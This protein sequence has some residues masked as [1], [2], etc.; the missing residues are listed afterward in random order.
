MF[1]IRNLMVYVC[2]YAWY[3]FD[4]TPP[5]E[6]RYF[7]G[8]QK[9]FGRSLENLERRTS[10]R[11]RGLCE[12]IHNSIFSTPPTKPVSP[13]AKCC[14]LKPDIWHPHHWFSFSLRR[15]IELMKK[16]DCLNFSFGFQRF[17]YDHSVSKMQI[18]IALFIVLIVRCGGWPSST[19]PETFYFS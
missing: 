18:T 13:L 11:R 15:D 17:R 3:A 9:M 10:V 4:P 14:R 2:M 16:M 19:W 1:W 8:S 5:P 12:C 6:A 7:S